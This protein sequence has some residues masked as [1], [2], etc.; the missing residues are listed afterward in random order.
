MIAKSTWLSIGHAMSG[1]TEDTW[2]GTKWREIGRRVKIKN[3]VKEK[4]E[5]SL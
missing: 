5:T 1:P 4:G 2:T 3:K